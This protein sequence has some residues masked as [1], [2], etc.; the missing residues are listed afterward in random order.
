M[1]LR[2]KILLAVTSL[3]CL[4]SLIVLGWEAIMTAVLVFTVFAVASKIVVAPLTFL[5][6]SLHDD[7]EDTVETIAS[8]DIPDIKRGKSAGTSP[9]P[10]LSRASALSIEHYWAWNAVSEI[11]HPTCR[12][13]VQ[14]V[15]AVSEPDFGNVAPVGIGLA[16]L[17]CV[18]AAGK[19]TG[20]PSTSSTTRASGFSYSSIAH[21]NSTRWQ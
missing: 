19:Y 9:K 15:F 10:I 12:L 4:T 7:R 1:I 18:Q 13:T 2:N 8:Q 5:W 11:N 6:Q 14:N 17:V 21:L 16:L 3:L 20:D